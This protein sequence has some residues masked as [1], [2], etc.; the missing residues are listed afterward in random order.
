M[1][2]TSSCL[3]L[4]ASVIL[5]RADEPKVEWKTYSPKGAK[6]E[7]QFP[8][9]GQEKTGK[10]TTQVLVNALEG[11]AVYMLMINDFPNEIKLEADLV[12]RIFDNG[13]DAGVKQLKG[14]ILSEKDIKLGK[15]P[16]RTF[17]MEV[18]G[19]GVYRTRLYVTPN[20]LYQVVVA[21][22]KAFV[23]SATSKKVFESFKLTD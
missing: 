11:K 19:L 9:K 16:G 8:G 10:G 1:R 5:V 13:R 22:P 15:T 14:K 21:G 18:P 3:V 20:K 6:A 17:D 12:K 2:L 7:V 23:D 4:L